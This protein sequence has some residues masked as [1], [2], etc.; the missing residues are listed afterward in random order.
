MAFTGSVYGDLGNNRIWANGGVATGLGNAG[1]NGYGGNDGQS[2]D[3]VFVSSDVN[4]PV[5]GYSGTC[6][7]TGTPLNLGSS[8]AMPDISFEITGFEPEPPVRA[9]PTMLAPTSLSR[10]C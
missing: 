2:P 4:Q 8:S 10:I 3:P 9:F 7:V 5:I 1:L 6:Y